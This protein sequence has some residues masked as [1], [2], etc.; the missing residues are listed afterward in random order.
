MS[1]LCLVAAV[2]SPGRAWPYVTRTSV[3]FWILHKGFCRWFDWRPRGVQG[4]NLDL[5]PWKQGGKGD[6]LHTSVGYMTKKKKQAWISWCS[7][8]SDVLQ[9]NLISHRLQRLARTWHETK[10]ERRAAL[11]QAPGCPFCCPPLCFVDAAPLFSEARGADVRSPPLFRNASAALF[12]R[13]MKF[14]NLPPPV[15]RSNNEVDDKIFQLL[16]DK[17]TNKKKQRAMGVISNK[18]RCHPSL[19]ATVGRKCFHFE[20]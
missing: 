19:T 6:G 4:T 11:A 12:A 10:T 3:L 14:C 8:I 16:N 1:E 18:Q 9:A 17:K 5:C 2:P 7:H 20:S 15:S 13:G